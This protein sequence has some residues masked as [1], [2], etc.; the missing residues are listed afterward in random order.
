MGVVGGGGHGSTQAL[1][2]DSPA[3]QR[4]FPDHMGVTVEQTFGDRL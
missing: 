1:T 4:A 2:A 3:V